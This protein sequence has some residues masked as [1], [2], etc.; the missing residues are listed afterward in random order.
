MC[1]AD[2]VECGDWDGLPFDGCSGRLSHGRHCALVD[3]VKVEF[4][5]GVEKDYASEERNGL[6]RKWSSSKILIRESELIT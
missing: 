1:E 6:K 5:C 4:L 2:R 3:R